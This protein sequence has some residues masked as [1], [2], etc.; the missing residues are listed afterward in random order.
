MHDWHENHKIIDIG[1]NEGELL[2]EELD[3]AGKAQVGLVPSGCG[4]VMGV[5]VPK[6]GFE[7]LET[8]LWYVVT[9]KCLLY[10][11]HAACKLCT[12][13]YSTA[14]SDVICIKQLHWWSAQLYRG[15]NLLLPKSSDNMSTTFQ[16]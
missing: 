3:V 6:I 8:M 4:Q 7:K 10:C 13:L 15:F 9:S 2:H 1:R 14:Y 16:I 11:M 12:S 5:V